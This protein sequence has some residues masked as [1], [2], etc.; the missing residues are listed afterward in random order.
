[1]KKI[2]PIL[3]VAIVVIAGALYFFMFSGDKESA[4]VYT[5]YS[6]GDFF[7]TNVKGANNLLKT[8]PILVLNTDKL[9][10]R[11]TAENAK[12]RDTINFVLSGFDAETLMS[13]NAR[14]KVKEAII[15]AVNE[16]LEIDNVVDVLF[17]DFVMQ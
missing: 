6:P 10:E 3:I 15:T 12:I 16:R 5:E 4:E 13:D 9:T 14:D 2:I 17:N 11:L 8:M 7:V 1:M